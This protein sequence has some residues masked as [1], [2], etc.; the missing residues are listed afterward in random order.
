[1][2]GSTEGP[3]SR[4]RFLAGT[5]TI[6]AGSA[7]VG[8]DRL[9]PS[10]GSSEGNETLKWME[11]YTVE[12]GAA[13]E[14]NRNWLQRVAGQFEEE[15]PGWTVEFEGYRWDEIDQRAILDL[16]AEVPHDVV[17]SSPQLMAKHAESETFA[18]L[19]PY[20]DGW[21]QSEREEFSWSP[22]WDAATFDSIQIGVP[23]GVH[24]RTLA[25]RRDL[26]EAA[27]LDPDPGFSSPEDIISIAGDLTKPDQWGLGIYMGPTRATIELAYS[28]M[29]WH[30]GG[31]FYDPDARQAVLTD[32]PNLQAVQWLYDL[33]HTHKIAPE[34][35]Y[36]P[37]VTYDDIC[38]NNLMDGTVAQSFGFG[39]Y[40]ISPVEDEGLVKGCF[41]PSAGC[42]AVDTNIVVVPTAEQALFTN[43]WLLSIHSLSEKQDMAWKLIETALRPDNLLDF[44][45][46]GL[47]ARL[48]A[49]ESKEYSS[50]FYRTWFEAARNGRSMPATPYYPELADAVAAALQDVLNGDGEVEPTMTRFEQ[51]WNERYANR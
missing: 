37:Q 49:W 2:A 8:C 33:V 27:G 18:D 6:A 9:N 45:D 14:A 50:D 26:L 36:A 15:N 13:S 29:V 51:E 1:M 25:Y 20:L 24:T 16:R 43:S 12:S 5:G 3:L 31:T 34:F 47:P 17:F 48:S 32:E 39:S 21:E 19:A 35:S 30:F 41:P 38:L 44:P 4:R 7:M 40:W 23:T 42:A 46:A 11:L 10:G 28:A 22:V